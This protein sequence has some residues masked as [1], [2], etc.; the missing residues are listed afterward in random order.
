MIQPDDNTSTARS[1][2][3]SSTPLTNSDPLPVP[4]PDQADAFLLVLGGSADEVFTF[5][6]FSERPDTK[7]HG[8]FTQVIHSTFAACVDRLISLNQQGASIYVTVNRTDGTGRKAENIIAC[9][10]AYIDHDEEK[11]GP[12]HEPLRIPPSITVFSGHGWHHYWIHAESEPTDGFT[13]TQQQLIAIYGSD[14]NV[15]DLPRVMRLPGFINWKRTPILARVTEIRA[16]AVYARHAVRAEHA[17]PSAIGTSTSANTNTRTASIDFAPA[18]HQKILDGCSWYRACHDNAATLTEP[19]WFA[20]LQ[21]AVRCANGRVIGHSVSSPYPRYSETETDK[22]LDHA[23]TFGPPTCSYVEGTLKHAGCQSC[24][25]RGRI[26]APIVLGSSAA[27]A[28]MSIDAARIIVTAAVAALIESKVELFM[29]ASTFEALAALPESERDQMVVRIRTAFAD[30]KKLA[31]VVPLSLFNK[32][33]AKALRSRRKEKPAAAAGKPGELPRIVTN[34]RPFRD[35]GDDALAALILANDPEPMVFVQACALVRVIP[36][37]DGLYRIE[38]FERP[39]LKGQLA[40]I[41][42]FVAERQTNEGVIDIPEVPS[43]DIVD[44]VLSR[45]SWPDLPMLVGVSP[46]PIARSDGT[47]RVDPGYD[48]DSRL[49]YLP[50]KNASIPHI[51]DLPTESDVANAARVL[52]EPFREFPWLDDSGRAHVFVLIFTLLLRPAIDGNV[53]LFIM[54]A[55]LPGSGKTLLLELVVSLVFGDQHWSTFPY[56]SSEDE[57]RKRITTALMEGQPVIVIDNAE[58]TVNSPAL[59]SAVT[60]RRWKDRILGGNTNASLVNGSSFIMNGN[61]LTTGDD[62]NRRS[63]LLEMRSTDEQ[64][65]T[66]GGFKIKRVRQLVR[67]HREQ[68][69][70]AALILIRHWHLQGR[71]QPTPPIVF[72]SFEEWSEVM[73]G[74]LHAA[75]IPGFMSNAARVRELNDGQSTQWG[76]FMLALF[77]RFFDQP[78]TVHRVCE[79]MPDP[80]DRFAPKGFHL[81]EEALPN[82]LASRRDRGAGSLQHALGQAFKKLVNTPYRGFTLQSAGIDPASNVKLWSVTCNDV[83]RLPEPQRSAFRLVTWLRAV[84]WWEFPENRGRS[85]ASDIERVTGALILTSG[86]AATMPALPETL[87]TTAEQVADLVNWLRT[88]WSFVTSDGKPMDDA[89]ITTTCARLFGES[90]P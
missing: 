42:D 23:A 11:D 89:L 41:A 53:P 72:G 2:S 6:T 38:A 81:F 78:F 70:S 25:H 35:I 19:N 21:V 1:T 33:L 60:S 85:P 58:G 17:T 31:K 34:G 40:R 76:G 71:P 69:L 47:F 14:S 50:G 30:N 86:L 45:G 22:K 66:R 74:I 46:I 43:N 28:A 84:S 44:D 64:P 55:N 68:L 62:L 54:L 10:A 82:E 52:W 26:K 87:V 83:E 24:P 65:H 57:I 63:C 4:D 15:H 90:S 37:A 80:H 56:V 7:G 13:A 79:E 51:I 18:D 61:N 32:R 29:A 36:D 16:G 27:T 67:E 5:Q 49:L 39:S 3:T 9:R 75:K 8:A 73:G 12:L 59:A 48:A 88:I 77:I 20:Q